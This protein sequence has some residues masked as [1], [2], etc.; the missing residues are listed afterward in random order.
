M[1]SP[2]ASGIKAGPPALVAGVL[3]AVGAYVVERDAWAASVLGGAA[4]IILFVGLG[5]PRV[6]NRPIWGR[7]RS[8]GERVGRALRRLFAFGLVVV[9][10]GFVLDSL[11]LTTLGVAFL[12]FWFVLLATRNL[13][14]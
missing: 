3:L 11:A 10:L 9:V 2:N 5:F 13:R 12:L 1:A 14:E 8:P 7:P 6:A 4:T